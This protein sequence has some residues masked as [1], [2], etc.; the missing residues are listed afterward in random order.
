[1]ANLVRSILLMYRKKLYCTI[2]NLNIAISIE[3]TFVNFEI[4]KAKSWKH[5][6]SKN[7]L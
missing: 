6:F 5:V 4:L 7:R 3:T 2:F 1:M